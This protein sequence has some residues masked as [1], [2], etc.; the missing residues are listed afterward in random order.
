MIGKAAL[1]PHLRSQH[2]SNINEVKSGLIEAQP[3]F[4]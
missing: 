3:K 2:T 1:H 4:E